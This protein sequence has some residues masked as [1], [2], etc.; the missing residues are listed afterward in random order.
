MP[1]SRTARDFLWFYYDKTGKEMGS[2]TSAGAAFWELDIKGLAEPAV[3]SP[4]KI[5]RV[6]LCIRLTQDEHGRTRNRIW[7]PTSV[8]LA[9]IS[10]SAGNL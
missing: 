1:G 7:I 2:V 5:S 3:K 9:L 6:P 4:K 8:F 10:A